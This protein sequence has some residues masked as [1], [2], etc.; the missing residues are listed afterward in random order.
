LNHSEGSR[1]RHYAQSIAT[2]RGLH[3]ELLPLAAQLRAAIDAEVPVIG[4]GRIVTTAEAE[5][6]L[7]SGRA[8][9]WA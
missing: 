5:S 1:N 3:A 4:V 9:W 2:W 7:R 8:I 6:A